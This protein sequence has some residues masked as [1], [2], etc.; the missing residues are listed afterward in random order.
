[1]QE[2]KF[3]KESLQEMSFLKEFQ[4][5]QDKSLAENFSKEPNREFVELWSKVRRKQDKHK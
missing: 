1:M 3:S 5:M 4:K 2:S